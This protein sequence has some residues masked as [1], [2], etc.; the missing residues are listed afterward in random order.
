MSGTGEGRADF[1]GEERLFRI[2]LG[3]IRR[4]E[5]QVRRR[6][7]RRGAAALSRCVYVTSELKGVQALAAG[8][9]IHADDVREPILQGLAGGGMSL[10][11]ATALVRAEIDDRGVRGLLDNASTALAM[12][13]GSQETP[14]GEP[15]A[16]E[17]PATPP[18]PSTSSTSTGSARRSASRPRRRPA[19][20]LGVQS[21]PSRAGRMANCAE[22]APSPPTPE[23]HDAMMAKYGG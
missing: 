15:R 17:S 10:A 5:A 8:L 9:E 20:G 2:R 14:P 19:D 16:G 21:R 12:L 3:E 7:H 4:I 11:D 13:W 23:E 1:A 18:K 6:R 22:E